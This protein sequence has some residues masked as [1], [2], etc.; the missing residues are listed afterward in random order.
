MFQLLQI[1]ETVPFRL[2]RDIIDG[3][4]PTGTEGTF[5]V[6]AEATTKV[7]RGN[8]SDLLTI[9]SA[10]VSDPLYKWCVSPITVHQHQRDEA[11]GSDNQYNRNEMRNFPSNNSDSDAIMAENEN[12]AAS[13]AIAKINEKLQGYEEGTLGER[14]T[15]EGQVRLLINAAREPSNL[16]LLFPGWSPWL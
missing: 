14:Q 16:S 15:V 8:S 5:T 9:L 1:P 10:V 7:L 4:G 3:M 11:D 13:R 6:A 12:D 2:T